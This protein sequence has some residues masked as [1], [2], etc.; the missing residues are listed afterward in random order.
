M[1]FLKITIF[2]YCISLQTL[3]QFSNDPAQFACQLEETIQSKTELDYQFFYE[4]FFKTF[5]SPAKAQQFLKEVEQ[6]GPQNRQFSSECMKLSLCVEDSALDKRFF[7]YDN[8]EILYQIA[9]QKQSKNNKIL[10]YNFE[11]QR[12]NKFISEMKIIDTRYQEDQ[13]TISSIYN[14][15]PN[16][17]QHINNHFDT[18][19]NYLKEQQA[20]NSYWLSKIDKDS[21]D[22]YILNVQICQT[23]A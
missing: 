2:I 9:A 7:D 21:D 10:W 8:L 17:I 6:C 23:K 16:E 19:I 18:R 11:Q 3:A 4:T 12:K 22:A 15:L 14:A 5:E 1:K 13:I 20:F